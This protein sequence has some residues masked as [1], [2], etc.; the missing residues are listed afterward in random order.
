MRKSAIE[1]NYIKSKYVRYMSNFFKNSDLSRSQ[2]ETIVNDTLISKDDGE[3][4]LQDSV[5]ES[6]TLDD[7][8]IKNTSYAKKYGMGLRGVVEDVVAYSHTNSISKQSLLDSSKN[9]NSTL[10]NFKS[11]KH[12]NSIRRSNENLYT[13]HNPINAKSLKEKIQLLHQVDQYLRSKSPLVKQVTA[14]I[15]AEKK[16]IEIIKS[17]GE[18]Y[19]DSQPT[20]SFRASIMMQKGSK[21][22]QG[23]YAN[24]GRFLFDEYINENNWK[25]VCDEAFRQAELNLDARKAP[26]GQMEVVLNNGWSGVL[27]HE[28]VGHTLEGDFLYKKSTLFHDKIGQQIANDQVTVVDQG[29]YQ[30]GRRGSINFDDE[31][32]KTQKN[33]LVDKGKLV[34]FMHDRLSARLTANK[35]TGNGR[36][37]S[38]QYAPMPRMTN[39]FMMNGKYERE[40]MIKSVKKGIYVDA[41]GGG[42]VDIV[43]GQFNFTVSNARLIENGELKESVEGATLI[44]SGSDVIQ[45]I[46]MLGNDLELDNGFGMCGKSGQTVQVGL[47]IPSCK[48]LMTVG[49]SKV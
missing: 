46:S 33:I 6:I 37:Q 9:I 49:G 47:G 19:S 41:L 16:L 28:A 8:K 10:R 22:T 5:V 24:G 23:S 26:A 43:S 45:N 17:G 25:K 3:L 13:D 39:T 36:R 18:T 20:T 12:D 27:L 7:G 30:G 1:L 21:N 34:G 32:E 40:E 14:S 29:N 48:I 38:Y 35:P 15:S 4:Y 44:G 2:V 31:A 42:S 11:K